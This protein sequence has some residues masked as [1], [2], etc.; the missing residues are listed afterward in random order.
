MISRAFLFIAWFLFTPAL[1]CG[2]G[3]G[4]RTPEG[5]SQQIYSLPCLTA[6]LPLHILT[7]ASGRVFP[8]TVLAIKDILPDSSLRLKCRG[9]LS[10]DFKPMPRAYYNTS[11]NYPH[12]IVF[13]G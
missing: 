5:I 2:A 6:S 13:V 4:I 11:L 7:C 12:K 1:V 10:V 8:V 9:N 3:G